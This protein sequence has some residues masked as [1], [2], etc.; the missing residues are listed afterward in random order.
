[1]PS[2]APP[3][4]LYPLLQLTHLTAGAT[5]ITITP[6]IGLPALPLLTAST[7]PLR[8]GIPAT[9]PLWLGLTLKKTRRAVLTPPPWLRAEALERAAAAERATPDDALLPPVDE[10]FL[11]VAA[12]VCAAAAEDVPEVARV[13]RALDDYAGVRAGK[14]RR[15]VRA[16]VGVPGGAPAGGGVAVKLPRVTRAE[17]AL[18]RD[19]VAR[20]CA[21]E[22]RLGREGGAASGTGGGTGEGDTTTG[23]GGTGTTE[24]GRQLRRVQM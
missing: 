12:S 9:V 20:V 16:Q 10:A 23:G 14:V 6:S 24:G 22:W 7:P 18:V 1:M 17:V 2:A 21:M 5:P 4:P 11:E 8:P 13:R 19:V 3:P 15:A